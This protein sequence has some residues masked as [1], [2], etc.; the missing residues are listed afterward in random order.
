MAQLPP[1][2]A[3]RAFE[4]AGRS[5]N[6]RVAAQAIGVTQGAVAQQVR[7][8]EAQLGMPLFDRL[9]NFLAFTS[10]GRGYHARIAAAFDELRAATDVLRPEPGKVL[11]SVTP[12]FAAK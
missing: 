4:A 9:P 12:S 8:L 5:L 3:L 7:L 11:V 6:F 10:S 2:N 1:L